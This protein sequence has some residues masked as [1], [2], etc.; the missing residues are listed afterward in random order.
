VTRTELV[1]ADEEYDEP[2]RWYAVAAFVVTVVG[3]FAVG[4]YCFLSWTSTCADKGL[5]TAA[6]GDST[7]A[8]LCESAHGAAVLVIPAGWVLG[9]ALASYALVKGGGSA[10]RVVLCAVLL[11]APVALPAAAYGGLRLSAATCSD[12]E[13]AAY[14]AWVDDGSEGTAPYACRTF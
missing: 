2:L 13:L 6:A 7:R 4:L 5:G 3:G 1:G 9:L 10:L 11:L 12:D 14:R 8:T